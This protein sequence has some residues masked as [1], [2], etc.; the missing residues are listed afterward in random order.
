MRFFILIL[1]AALLQNCVPRENK[2]NANEELLNKIDSLQSELKELKNLQQKDSIITDTI[3]KQVQ[4]TIAP[5]KILKQKETNT[6]VSPSPK[7]EKTI[8]PKNI[9]EKFYYKNSKR[10]SVI[11]T[12]WLDGKR[13]VTLFDTLGN[14]TYRF[15]DVR[16]SY[17][18]TTEIKEFHQNGAVSKMH[19][20]INPGASMYWYDTDI[21]FD[22]NNVPISKMELR[23]PASLDDNMNGK[24]LWNRETKSWEKHNPAQ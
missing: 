11:V 10:I 15:K 19:N 1:L 4:P 2:S 7:P 5:Q 21:Y 14:E 6:K 20:H 8:L 24:S 9:V 13:T 12:P 18:N 3:I 16:L 23:Q 22:I 17:S